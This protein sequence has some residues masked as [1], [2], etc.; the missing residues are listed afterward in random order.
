MERGS[1]CNWMKPWYGCLPLACLLLGACSVTV[2][3]TAPQPS[4]P[5]VDPPLSTPAPSSAD[6]G[7]RVKHVNSA[8]EQQA[9]ASSQ[10]RDLARVL[11]I[12]A[13][14]PYGLKLVRATLI[15]NDGDVLSG[16]FRVYC[17]TRMIRPTQYRLETAA[18]ELKKE[19]E[20]W[21]E[22]FQ[23]RWNAEQ[24]LIAKVCN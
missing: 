5:Q 2:N 10:E 9:R 1:S 12:R 21:D 13:G 8:P 22:A 20:W 11:S 23:P 6:Q 17:P 18:G 14:E 16:L 15:Y 19:G 3:Q 7:K 24:S 4:S